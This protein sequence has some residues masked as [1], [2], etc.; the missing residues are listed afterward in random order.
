M[1][2]TNNKFNAS[3]VNKRLEWT[4]KELA[5]V[6]IRVIGLASDGDSRLL[7]TMMFRVIT[8]STL[9]SWKWF[10][11][12]LIVLFVCMQDFI[13][14]ATKLKSRL[15]KASIILALGIFLVSRG[16][17]VELIK[18]ASK[19]LH[20][21]T[22]SGINPKD[23]MNY[24]A[25]QKMSDKQVTA[26]LRS[27]V[28]NSEGTATY[29][30]MMREVNEAFSSRSLTPLERVEMIWQWV[31]FL[32]IWRQWIHDKDGYTIQNNFITSNA[33]Y[34]IEI[35]AHCLIQTIVK[36]R[37][38]EEP[39]LFKPW[40]G[41][42]QP[43]ENT[44]R[45]MRSGATTHCGV[46]SF[47]I[48]E[49]QNHFRRVDLLC[50]SH[51]KLQNDFVFPRHH[52]A[53]KKN[54]DPPHIPVSLPEDYEIEAAV[55]SAR[56]KAV[57][58]AEKF[59]LI[60]KPSKSFV[61]PPNLRTIPVREM[62]TN[63]QDEVESES[64]DEDEPNSSENDNDDDNAEDQSESDSEDESCNE[65]DKEDELRDAFEDLFVLSCGPLGLKTFNHMTVTLTCPF[66]VVDDG[67]GNRAVIRKSTLLWL[68]SN[69]YTKLSPDRLLRVA[70]D[71]VD[72]LNTRNH[73]RGLASPRHEEEIMLGDW[74]FGP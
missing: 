74:C 4:E 59:K 60:Q 62:H 63:V 29:L 55:L 45:K 48:L 44:F 6:G 19:G 30:D 3:Q 49:L 56:D 71:H 61:P 65:Q 22:L 42:S 70:A 66:V 46:V 54:G 23:K 50:S 18:K 21:L 24:R 33:Y 72:Q 43:C 14:I 7:K 51:S 73:L 17:L 27:E 28:P 53:F 57:K 1:F 34:C 58:I 69:G 35:N 47:S 26:L 20:K 25:V 31:F 13:H 2:G 64:E 5:K 67:E 37:E 10:Q 52:K 9:P 41:S 12:Q 39:H 15:L 11:A 40:L 32:R 36:L 8:P 16:H 38:R 68:L